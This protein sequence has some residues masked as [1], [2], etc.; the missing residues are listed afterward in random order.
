LGIGIGRLLGD[1]A[2]RTRADRGK[3]I[4][5]RDIDRVGAGAVVD[6]EVEAIAA[7]SRGMRALCSSERDAI[8]LEAR[9]RVIAL[10]SVPRGQSSIAAGRAPLARRR[11]DF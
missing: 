11:Q 9:N 2:G 6:G 10:A 5:W 4:T 3:V 1:R 7:G 8:G